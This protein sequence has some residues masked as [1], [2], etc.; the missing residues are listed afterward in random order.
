MKRKDV[1]LCD[2][3][4][5][6]ILSIQYEKVRKYLIACGLGD[7]AQ[8]DILQETMYT[9]WRKIEDLRE[10]EKLDAW[11]RSVAQNYVR[12]F[13]RKR[14]KE[15]LRVCSYEKLMEEAGSAIPAVLIYEEMERFSDSALYEMIVALGE[16]AKTILLLHYQAGE[17]FNR[18]AWML[19]M[20]PST[21][22][23][24]AARSRE[25]LKKE[26]MKGGRRL[27]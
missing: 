22:R 13:F 4:V 3:E 20:N 2:E 1:S 19:G 7:G 9:V 18:I 26:I 23:S 17:D 21:V 15:L 11:V 6:E 16:P 8:E 24:I 12:K 5:I 14:K 10:P 27:G 25:K